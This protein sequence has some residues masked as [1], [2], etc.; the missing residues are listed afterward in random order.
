M[1]SPFYFTEV[2]MSF[3]FTGT[4]DAAHDR[5]PAQFESQALAHLK[6]AICGYPNDKPPGHV[7]PES[8]TFR[9]ARTVF[10]PN[11]ES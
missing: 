4:A 3:R 6:M 1:S 7:E 9:K 2:T 5:N 8:V 11:E 10:C